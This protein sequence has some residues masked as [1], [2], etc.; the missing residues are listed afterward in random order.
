MSFCIAQNP[1]DQKAGE[2]KEKIHPH[3]RSI[4]KFTDDVIKTGAFAHDVEVMEQNR[5]DCYAPKS[6]QCRNAL[7]E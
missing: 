4:R 3:P 7:S 2:D 6:I 5:K 1:G